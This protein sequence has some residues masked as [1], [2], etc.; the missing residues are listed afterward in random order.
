MVRAMHLDYAFPGQ[1]LE[2][3]DLVFVS[4]DPLSHLYYTL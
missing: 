1:R 2:F 3:G 4:C